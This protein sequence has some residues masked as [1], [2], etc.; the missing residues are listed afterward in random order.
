MAWL[1]EAEEGVLH[2]ESTRKVPSPDEVN[3]GRCASQLRHPYIA[4]DAADSSSVSSSSQG[5]GA[6]TGA[7]IGMVDRRNLVRRPEGVN[8]RRTL[9][10]APTAVPTDAIIADAT[11]ATASYE[12]QMMILRPLA[13]PPPPPS[14]DIQRPQPATPKAV[15]QE[16]GG[17]S[18]LQ[19]ARS[20][21]S[22]LSVPFLSAHPQRAA[23]PSD[24]VLRKDSSSELAVAPKT[25]RRAADCNGKAMARVDHKL[26][27]PGEVTPVEIQLQHVEPDLRSPT[28]SPHTRSHSLRTPSRSPSGLLRGG[29]AK[30]PIGHPP[31]LPSLARQRSSSSP[32]QSHDEPTKS[33]SNLLAHVAMLP[34]GVAS[35][36]GRQLTSMRRSMEGFDA[37]GSRVVDADDCH[38]VIGTELQLC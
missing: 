1:Q 15:A 38:T 29:A 37:D 36:P 13:R 16:Q 33:H 9:S 24:S 7:V 31:S 25:V 18:R 21:R 28:R 6:A 35:A 2:D 23:Q 11:C 10:T 17:T 4:A 5:T 26:L 22:V 30:V 32:R 12:E 19:S 14:S 20:L 8:S 3:D 34:R 27:V